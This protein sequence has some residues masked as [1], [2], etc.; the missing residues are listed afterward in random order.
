MPCSGH[1]PTLGRRR[2]II[3]CSTHQTAS[4]LYKPNVALDTD[5][6]CPWI[7]G[8]SA[9][10][11][12]QVDLP[13]HEELPRLEYWVVGQSRAR[14]STKHLSVRRRAGVRVCHCHPHLLVR[15]QA[16]QDRKVW[17]L[18]WIQVATWGY[19]LLLPHG[20]QAN[21]HWDRSPLHQWAGR[22]RPLPSRANRSPSMRLMRR[23][24]L[25]R[26]QVLNRA[27]PFTAVLHATRVCKESA[28]AEMQAVQLVKET[29]PTTI[30]GRR[31]WK[32][33]QQNLLI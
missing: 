7:S 17:A 13:L 24:L 8:G 14:P 26:L 31:I 16:A 23:L 19:L 33:V 15:P 21:L 10:R 30:H 25:D 29:S 5:N 2:N 9:I 18:V 12:L 20:D 11:N 6:M 1:Q 3:S 22:R 4:S 28:N 32:G 27:V